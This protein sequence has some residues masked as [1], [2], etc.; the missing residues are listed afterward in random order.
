VL[1]RV[2][3]WVN[4]S[5]LEF[6]ERAS[7]VGALLLLPRGATFPPLFRSSLSFVELPAAPTMYARASSRLT[8][9]ARLHAALRSVAP[10]AAAARAATSHL[11]GLLCGNS[12]APPLPLCA[13]RRMHD[14]AAL[15]GGG[16]TGAGIP[17][18]AMER[19]AAL[20][21]RRGTPLSFAVSAAVAAGAITVSPAPPF[22]ASTAAAAEAVSPAD[23]EALAEPELA[24]SM[25]ALKLRELSTLLRYR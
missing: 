6:V 20:L 7:V 15:R 14:V 9:A 12:A 23:A 24:P 21:P 25:C 10:L 19:G 2:R 3:A 11:C 22:G 4:R 8:G 16:V 5:S 17:A 18:G 13:A 1:R